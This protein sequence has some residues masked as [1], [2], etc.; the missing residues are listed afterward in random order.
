[1][2]LTGLRDGGSIGIRVSRQRDSLACRK[3]LPEVAPHVPVLPENASAGRSRAEFAERCQAADCTTRPT[4]Q[5]KSIGSWGTALR[6]AGI[7]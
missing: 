7:A 2:P 4:G 3:L 1:M 5:T 6:S